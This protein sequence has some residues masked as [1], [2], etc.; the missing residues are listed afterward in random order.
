M[1]IKHQQVT[2]VIAEREGTETEYKVSATHDLSTFITENHI[3]LYNGESIKKG[4]SPTSLNIKKKA[5]L[6]LLP[7]NG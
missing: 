7:R 3:L 4:D 1:S 6:D 2:I 5:I